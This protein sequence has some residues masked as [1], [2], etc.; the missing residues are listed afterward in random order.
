MGVDEHWRPIDGMRC[1][2]S[3]V[4]NEDMS[5]GGWRSRE[6]RGGWGAAE[7]GIGSDVLG[8]A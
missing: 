4:D 1:S 8:V 3:R 2:G 7:S 5:E 6:Q